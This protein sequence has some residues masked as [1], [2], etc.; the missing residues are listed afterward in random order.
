MYVLNAISIYL[1]CKM[2]LLKSNLYCMYFTMKTLLYENRAEP[3][4]MSVIRYYC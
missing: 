4:Y 3:K 2:I 1:V